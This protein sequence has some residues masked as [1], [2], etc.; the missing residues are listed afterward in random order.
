[1]KHTYV[2]KIIENNKLCWKVLKRERT[3]EDYRS[4]ERFSL[5]I[6]LAMLAIALFNQ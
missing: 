4:S 5:F 3:I 6:F 1:M 2:I